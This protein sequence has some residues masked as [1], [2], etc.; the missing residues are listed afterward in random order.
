VNALRAEGTKV[1][2]F[3][4]GRAEQDVM[5]NDFMSRDRVDKIVQQSFLAAGAYAA[6]PEIRP[7]LG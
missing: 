2:V 7:L 4:P 6:R 5:G 3:R 1:V